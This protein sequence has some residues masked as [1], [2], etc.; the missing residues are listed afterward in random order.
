MAANHKSNQSRQIREYFENL[1]GQEGDDRKASALRNTLRSKAVKLLLEF[2]NTE[3]G[4]TAL[5]NGFIEHLIA[6]QPDAFVWA[7]GSTLGDPARPIFYTVK[8]WSD[9]LKAM[10]LEQFEA[11]LNSNQHVSDNAATELFL[12]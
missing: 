1:Q 11:D 8:T 7:H 6:S 2:A 10:M 3:K 5:A 9:D 4:M 12:N